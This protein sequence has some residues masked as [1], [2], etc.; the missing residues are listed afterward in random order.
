MW[1]GPATLEPFGSSSFNHPRISLASALELQ[2]CMLPT[3]CSALHLR[4]RHPAHYNVLQDFGTDSFGIGMGQFEATHTCHVD[5]HSCGELHANH[6][7][8]HSLIGL[9]LVHSKDAVK[10]LVHE[11]RNSYGLNLMSRDTP[12]PTAHL[13][14]YYTTHRG[15]KESLSWE[16]YAGTFIDLYAAIK[17]QCVVLGYG[18]FTVLAIK[19]GNHKCVVSYMINRQREMASMWGYETV[20]PSTRECDNPIEAFPR[21]RWDV[22]AGNH[23]GPCCRG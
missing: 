16:S 19:I 6:A 21:A 9:R 10:Y 2:T 5:C 18:N 12:V 8:K 11:I 14:A 4:V 23:Q 7:G 17:A 13:D 3:N 20:G 1:N 15:C 22:D